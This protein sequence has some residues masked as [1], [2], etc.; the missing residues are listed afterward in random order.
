MC[1]NEE[2]KA[3]KNTL[4]RK[5][6]EKTTYTHQEGITRIEKEERTPVSSEQQHELEEESNI[7]TKTKRKK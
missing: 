4:K 2:S 5:T 3:K 6:G 1:V 7:R